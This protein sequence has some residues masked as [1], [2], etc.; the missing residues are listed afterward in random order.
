MYSTNQAYKIN[1]R[2][3][4]NE[5]SLI[6]FFT[7]KICRKQSVEQTTDIFRINSEDHAGFSEKFS[8]TFLDKT[9]SQNHENYWIRTLN[10]LPRA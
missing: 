7:C 8:V 3:N 1:Y 10:T 2:F 4:C 9:D 5:S 6:Y